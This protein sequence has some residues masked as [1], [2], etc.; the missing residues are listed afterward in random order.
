MQMRG[1]LLI[2]PW[3]AYRF[4]TNAVKEQSIVSFDDAIY[5]CITS[6]QAGATFAENIDKFSSVGTGGSG[7]LVPQGEWNVAESTVVSPTEALPLL[8]TDLKDALLVSENFIASADLQTFPFAGPFFIFGG[9]TSNTV[10]NDF[11]TT[12]WVTINVSGFSNWALY[13]STGI[14]T[15]Q[16]IVDVI[17]NVSIGGGTSPIIGLFGTA[18]SAFGSVNITLKYNGPNDTNINV[19]TLTDGD[20]PELINAQTVSVGINLA[21]GKVYVL[22][23]VTTVLEFDIPTTVLQDAGEL[24]FFAGGVYGNVFG[25]GS[26]QISFPQPEIYSP[27]TMLRNGTITTPPIDA[28][29]GSLWKITTNGTYDY[30]NVGI[31]DYVL[32]F[33]ELSNVVVF[34]NNVQELALIQSSL[35]TI[36]TEISTGLVDVKERAIMRGIIDYVTTAP[37]SPIVGNTWLTDATPIGMFS[38]FTL[39]VY[40]GTNWINVDP[41]EGVVFNYSEYNIQIK[42]II[43]NGHRNSSNK[44]ILKRNQSINININDLLA[45]LNDPSNN[46]WFIVDDVIPTGLYPSA[47]FLS[48]TNLYLTW[49]EYDDIVVD[50]TDENF[51]S[52]NFNLVYEP[53]DLFDII[54]NTM[55]FKN[56]TNST[57]NILFDSPNYPI[58]A[59]NPFISTHFNIPPQCDLILKSRLVLKEGVNDEAILLEYV[60]GSYVKS[61]SYVLS[62]AGSSVSVSDNVTQYFLNVDSID[63]F[64]ILQ[65][66]TTLVDGQTFDFYYQASVAN[67]SIH[68]VINYGQ[69]TFDVT[70]SVEPGDKY[71]KVRYNNSILEVY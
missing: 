13:D 70:L 44:R 50:L 15:D 53:T 1:G 45:L 33:N 20:I 64:E 31:N 57:I 59:C 18:G 66:V 38:S 61:N 60:S 25:V 49:R 24:S 5:V 37:V 56:L 58:R 40:D 63:A 71:N 34:E 65:T 23:D 14:T 11:S 42:F 48:Q 3:K 36:S 16:A 35:S 69:G 29:D 46:S 30:Q 52:F 55:Y 22:T 51:T 6:H 43:D 47:T 62:T 4:Y 28:V 12:K 7:A 41:S 68:F 39:Y 26:A 8:L 10:I 19:F 67:S 2:E 21:L 54:P 27:I 32:F 9:F 17:M